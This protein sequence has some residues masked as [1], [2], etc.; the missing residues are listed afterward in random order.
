MLTLQ[1]LIENAI[2]HNVL[3]DNHPLEIKIEQ[4]G[5]HIRVENN[6]NPKPVAGS[7]GIGL[8]NLNKRFKFVRLYS[9]FVDNNLYSL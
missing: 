4:I 5:A 6:L 3:T 2:K 7:L 8:V 1:M 9:V